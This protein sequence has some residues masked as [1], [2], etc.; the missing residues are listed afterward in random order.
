MD[1]ISHAK[2]TNNP[3]CKFHVVANGHCHWWAEKKL[4]KASGH[5]ILLPNCI[6]LLKYILLL[7]IHKWSTIIS[8]KLWRTARH[9]IFVTKWTKLCV[10][11]QFSTIQLFVNLIMCKNCHQGGCLFVQ[12]PE[13]KHTQHTAKSGILLRPY[14]HNN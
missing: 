12:A 3:F 14:T 9:Y 11:Y 7:G 2:G 8:R 1:C 5:P 13:L 4:T 10:I 6:S